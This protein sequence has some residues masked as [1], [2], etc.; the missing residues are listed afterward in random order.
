MSVCECFL[1]VLMSRC[2]V[3]RFRPDPIPR[4]VVEKILEAGIRAPTAGGG[5]QWFFIAVVDEA[6]RRELHRLLVEAHKKYATE[7]L[8][9]PMPKEKIEKWFRRMEEEGMYYA[10][11]YIAAYLDLRRKL[12]RD[13][14]S[15][16]ERLWAI[17]SVSA[18]IENML[19]AAHALGLGAVWLGVPLL[20]REE[21]NSV[22]QPP[23]GCE[24]QGII[25][26]GYP[27]EEPRLRPRK[28]LG[29]VSRIV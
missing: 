18:A 11:L 17:H 21:F 22:L 12:Y 2:S 15:D 9:S 20:I 26:V 13:E 29:E 19:L 24:L 8:R 28:S 14:Y 7:V 3:R 16:L 4:E 6:K 1:D 27:A 5:E 25:A 10:P 23:T